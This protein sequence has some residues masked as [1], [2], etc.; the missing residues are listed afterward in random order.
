MSALLF[1]IVC[2]TKK[3]KTRVQ[4]PYT[5]SCVTGKGLKHSAVDSRMLIS[6]LNI[7]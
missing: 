1:A 4:H 2:I 7:L 6:C 3:H 5:L